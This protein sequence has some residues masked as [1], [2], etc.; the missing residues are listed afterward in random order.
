MTLPEAPSSN[1]GSVMQPC[2]EKMLTAGVP[3]T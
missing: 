3:S 1:T 2:Y